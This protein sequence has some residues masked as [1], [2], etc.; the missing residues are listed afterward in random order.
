MPVSKFKSIFKR[1]S[2]IFS[3]EQKSFIIDFSSIVINL[4]LNKNPP[5]LFFFSTKLHLYSWFFATKIVYTA[6]CTFLQ[7]Y[8]EVKIIFELNNKHETKKKTK[9]I[10]KIMFFML[11]IIISFFSDFLEN[12]I[13][14]VRFFGHPFLAPSGS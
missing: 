13:D 6:F 8:D 11:Y 1:L 14:F 12:L 4:F 9:S 2:P 5:K 7:N 10:L 3:T